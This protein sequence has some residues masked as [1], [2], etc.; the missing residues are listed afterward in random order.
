MPDKS[1]SLPSDIAAIVLG[2]GSDQNQSLR[3]SSVVVS[4]AS[5]SSS[6]VR[7][8]GNSHGKNQS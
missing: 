4:I 8:L 7:T 2:Y 3:I 6:I 5:S 1:K